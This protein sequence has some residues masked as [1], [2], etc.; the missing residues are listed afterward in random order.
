MRGERCCIP[1]CDLTLE[2]KHQVCL[3][4]YLSIVRASDPKF[5]AS[6]VRVTDLESTAWLGATIALRTDYDDELFAQCLDSLEKKWI[7]P[8]L[9]TVLR[10]GRA[11]QSVPPERT[12]RL[13]RQLS[14]DNVQDSLFLLVELLDSIPFNDSSPFNSDFVFDVVSQFVPGGKNRDEMHG[15][16]WKNVCSKLIEGRKLQTPA[17]RFFAYRNGQGLPLELRLQRVAPLA[18]ELVKADPIEA[19]NIVKAH[20]ELSLPEWRDDLIQWLKNSLSG[21]D[22]NDSRGAI[23]DL[24]VPEILDW[25]KE[26]PEPRSVLMAHAAPRTLDDEY[27]GRLT[28][29]LL[30]RYGQF[31]GVRIGISATFHSGG[32]G[33][34]QQVFT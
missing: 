11:I 33:L 27:G 6:T 1:L 5:Y 16:H 2:T 24:P 25:I 4:G 26:D 7:D 20:F 21:F 30:H 12:W 9:F 3:H 28:R 14:K 34:A 10:F 22:E 23:V 8:Q 17:I 18:N 15:Y 29:E 31:D 19:W 32:N 13:L